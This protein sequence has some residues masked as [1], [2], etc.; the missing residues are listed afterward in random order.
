MLKNDS[1]LL[2]LPINDADSWFI[3][4]RARTP[5][6]EAGGVT[7]AS[8]RVR[9]EISLQ[10][11]VSGY[12]RD[13]FSYRLFAD[14]VVRRYDG[15]DPYAN[16]DRRALSIEELIASDNM[17]RDELVDLVQNSRE[18]LVSVDIPNQRLEREMGLQLQ[19]IGLEELDGM[20]DLVTQRGVIP[21]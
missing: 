3:S 1:L 21:S 18:R 12:G 10:R 4:V 17:P 6:D 14:G 20:T 19:P 11:I 8:E 15:G 16:P 7:T 5:P 2:R 9:K 13:G